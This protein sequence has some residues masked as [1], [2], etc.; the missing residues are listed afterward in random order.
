MSL[1]FV[2]ITNSTKREAPRQISPHQFWFSGIFLL[3]GY[4]QYIKIEK[5]ILILLFRDSFY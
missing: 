4:F 5:E 3:T 2:Y 1:I